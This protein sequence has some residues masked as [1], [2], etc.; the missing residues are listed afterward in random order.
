MSRRFERTFRRLAHERQLVTWLALIS[1]LLAGF[2][3]GTAAKAAGLN[4]RVTS[5]GVN[6]EISNHAVDFTVEFS[7]GQADKSNSCSSLI[8]AIEK[9]LGFEF[10]IEGQRATWKARDFAISDG[11]I[12]A[13]ALTCGFKGKFAIATFDET[14]ESTSVIM[15]VL[16]VDTAL[17]SAQ[18]K[19]LNPNFLGMLTITSPTR[20]QNV[21]GY[22]NV[23][24]STYGGAG[25]RFDSLFIS[26][27]KQECYNGSQAIQL[28]PSYKEGSDSSGFAALEDDGSISAYF[29]GSG[30]F[31]IKLRAMFGSIKAENSVF[32][33]VQKSLE[34]TVIPWESALSLINN[35]DVSL[36]LTS[37]L[38]CGNSSL[39][40]NKARNCTIKVETKTYSN[41]TSLLNAE[42]PVAISTSLNGGAY[43]V[44]KRLK[45]QAGKSTPLSVPVAKTG[46]S[47]AIQIAIEGYASTG[48]SFSSNASD[49]ESWGPPPASISMS[50]P[51]S[52]QWG[53]A[54]KI[55]IS[56]KKNAKGSCKILQNNISTIAT[57]NIVNGKGS[58]QT[59][60]V[61]GGGIGSTVT[62]PL[63]AYCTI[64]GA[65]ST[66]YRYTI[67]VR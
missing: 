17:A 13:N 16:M 47:F 11:A 21:S 26:I 63:F 37:E 44:V 67:G 38:D 62:L 20:G 15:S 40:W 2:G 36:G 45:V 50:V 32:V 52:I 22:T 61:W 14:E 24:F 25:K 28:L 65:N 1:V 56:S 53:K 8:Q 31:E 64:G 33:N 49:V 12:S 54:F 46:N 35:P 4:A 43:R 19:L 66:A 34:Q 30:I 57:I 58:T 59:K 48:G 60:L 9:D 6:N 42:V 41:N 5:F 23:A 29:V 18:G 39:T 3:G 7:G 51:S 27:C 10:T 55:S